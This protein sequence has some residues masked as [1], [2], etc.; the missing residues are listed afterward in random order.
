MR[1]LLD[2][3]EVRVD[4]F[5]CPGH[6]SVVIGSQPYEFI[7]REYGVPCVITG[8]EPVDILQGIEMLLR[9][10]AVGRAEV[11]IQYSRGV[12]PEGNPLA[13]EAMYRVFRE[14]DA[15]WRG[16]GIIPASGLKLRPEY[17]RFDAE[18][19][20]AV[21]PPP[22]KE[23]KGCICGEIL[24]GVKTP[25]ECPIFGSACTPESPVG[26]CMVSAEGTCAGWYQYGPR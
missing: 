5:I 10:I 24:R 16:L 2:S 19:A 12:R 7:A 6:V 20:F 9:Q 13:L 18:A 3:G 14:A 15:G 17:A 26:P 8:F 11:E 23:H 4:G 21:R 25:P 22:T 1:A